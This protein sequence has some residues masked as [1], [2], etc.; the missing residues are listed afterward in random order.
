MDADGHDLVQ[1]TGQPNVCDGEPSFTPDGRRIMFSR[2][3]AGRHGTF[4]S[5]RSAGARRCRR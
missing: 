2:F 5:R 3:D 1:L 4:S